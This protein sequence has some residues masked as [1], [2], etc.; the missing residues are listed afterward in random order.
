MS[1]RNINF[2]RNIY[3]TPS[4]AHGKEKKINLLSKLI[5]CNSMVYICLLIQLC[6]FSFCI[7]ILYKQNHNILFPG[8]FTIV[9]EIVCCTMYGFVLAGDYTLLTSNILNQLTNPEYSICKAI[10]LDTLAY[11]FLVIGI[12]CF[13]RK[14]KYL[15]REKGRLSMWKRGNLFLLIISLILI[16]LF[17]RNVGGLIYYLNNLGIRQILNS[18]NGYLNYTFVLSLCCC[19]FFYAYLQNRTIKRLYSFLTMFLFTL[20]M[21]IIYGGRNPIL[22]FLMMLCA[23]YN[24]TYK[25]ISISRFIN[26]KTLIIVLFTCFVFVALPAFRSTNI[27]DD[28]KSE[29][30]SAIVDSISD[31]SVTSLMAA[32]T[33]NRYTFIYEYY[34]NWD[35]KWIFSSYLDLIPSFIPR[36]I[37]PEKPPM[38]EGLYIQSTI[39]TGINYKPSMSS[40]DLPSKASMPPGITIGYINFGI[41]GLCLSTFIQGYI[42]SYFYFFALNS[43]SFIGSC[44]Y[45]NIL[46]NFGLSNLS[47]GYCLVNIIYILFISVFCYKSRMYRTIKKV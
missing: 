41:I 4:T 30:I 1:D 17:F 7:Y 18:G 45:I 15:M 10:L 23:I 32:N 9:K 11:I 3:E 47:I 24:F 6:I 27:Y 5:L 21:L 29:G 28:L 44:I 35:N 8:L 2:K 36:N 20:L 33:L 38:D 26:I 22:L 42:I 25:K 14:P 12:L 40:D 39:N 16:V 34:E 19:G 43:K 31:A 46:L 13:K 37:Y